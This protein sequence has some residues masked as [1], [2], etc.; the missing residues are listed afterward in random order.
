LNSDLPNVPQ[1][2][3]SRIKKPPDKLRF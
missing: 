2:R 1:R 3:S